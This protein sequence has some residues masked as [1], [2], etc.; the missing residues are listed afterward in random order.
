M[1]IETPPT[2]QPPRNKGG[3]P[4]GSKTR[5]KWLL[6]ELKKAPK[7]P[8]GRPKGAKNKPKTLE[9]LIDLALNPPPP[10][11]K[12]KRKRE[13]QGYVGKPRDA[14]FARLK[15]ENP[16][17][18]SEISRAAAN[19]EARKAKPSK[20]AGNPLGT[21]NHEAALQREEA[22][23]IAQRIFKLMDMEGALPDNPIARKAM[24]EAV[25]MLAT[26]LPTKDK[27]AKPAATSNVNLRTA[28]DFLDELAEEDAK[29]A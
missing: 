14:Y 24:K 10:P 3:R 21:T 9:A 15:R 20:I 23:K 18:L 25:E 6:D 1:S 13:R 7:R 11:P 12:P 27:L 2:D 22:R 8:R 19:S 5:P 17:K 29:P 4:K 16:E 28:E 26:D